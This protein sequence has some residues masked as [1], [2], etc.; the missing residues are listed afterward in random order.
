MDCD[1]RRENPKTEKPPAV[2]RTVVFEASTDELLRCLGNFVFARCAG[3]PG[4][5]PTRIV[6]WIKRPDEQLHAQGWHRAKFLQPATA[7]F[8]FMVAKEAIPATNSVAT[9]EEVRRRLMACLY[10]SC[11]VAGAEISYPLRP[12]INQVQ[13]GSRA[14]FWDLCCDLVTRM[15]GKMLE[16]SRDEKYFAAL[17]KQ[18]RVFDD[19]GCHDDRK[20]GFRSGPELVKC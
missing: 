13:Q 5:S 19:V 3:V 6:A 11:A 14:A 17:F 20:S 16:I 12:F 18:L 7:V 4:V 9:E 1:Y 10:V 2:S 8:L 15:S